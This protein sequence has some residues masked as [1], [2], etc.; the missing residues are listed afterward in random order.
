MLSMQMGHE[1]VEKES[2]MTNVKYTIFCETMGVKVYQCSSSVI[3]SHGCEDLRKY[4]VHKASLNNF[5]KSHETFALAN[6]SASCI[7]PLSGKKTFPDFFLAVIDMVIYGQCLDC[8]RWDDGTVGSDYNFRCEDCNE[9]HS[10]LTTRCYSYAEIID[11]KT[12]LC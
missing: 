8:E 4:R 10:I 1:L 11:S 2:R 3:N 6:T 12:K 5:P 7:I 9:S